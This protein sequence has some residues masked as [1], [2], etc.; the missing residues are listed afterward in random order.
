MTPTDA[1]GFTVFGRGDLHGAKAFP[2]LR[3]WRGHL[4]EACPLHP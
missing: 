2:V 4:G 3:Q 1:A